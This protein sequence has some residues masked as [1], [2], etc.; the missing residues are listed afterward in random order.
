MVDV[1]CRTNIMC[2]SN[3][4]AEACENIFFCNVLGEEECLIAL[5]CG[6]NCFLFCTKLFD[7]L[8]KLFKV[9]LS[10]DSCLGKIVSEK[11]F[12]VY[13]GV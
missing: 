7:E 4:I 1:I 5:C 9:Y 10:V 13:R 8:Y 3:K 11:C 2:K 6:N 12:G